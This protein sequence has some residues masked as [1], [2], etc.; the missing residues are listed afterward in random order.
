M[1]FMDLLK[2]AGGTGSIGALS[3]QLGIGDGDT[4]KLVEALGP[5]LTRGLQKQT[6]NPATLDGLTKALSGGNHQRYL[7]DPD[8]V[9]REDAITDGNKILGHL[10]GSKDV[11]RNVAAQAAQQTGLESSLIKKALPLLA[12][13]A[14]GA[15]SKKGPENEKSGGLGGLLGGLLGGGNDGIDLDDVLGLARKLF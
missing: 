2:E 13:L 14:M 5:A 11:S 1:N 12:G 6:E 8:L 4:G 15:L 3:K 9:G 10:F 7:D